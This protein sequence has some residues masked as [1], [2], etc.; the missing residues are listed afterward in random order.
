MEAVE[1]YLNKHL[2]ILQLFGGLM[3]TLITLTAYAYTTFATKEDVKYA[4]QD[5]KEILL[6]VEKNVDKLDE[7]IDRILE[8][9]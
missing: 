2:G 8:G 3:A 4:I 5:T 6:R 7:K 9:K 1:K